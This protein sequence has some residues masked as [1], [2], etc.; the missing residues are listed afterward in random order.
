MENRPIPTAPD[1]ENLMT[2]GEMI[3]AAIYLPL[4][5]LGVP[6]VWQSNNQKVVDMRIR[7]RW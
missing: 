5:V 2:R 4:H 6:S 3:A 7:C 1:F